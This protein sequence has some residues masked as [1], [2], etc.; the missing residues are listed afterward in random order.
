MKK[1]LSNYIEEHLSNIVIISCILFLGIFC[2]I[3]LFNF[4]GSEF[5]ENV[6]N[7][8]KE[9]MNLMQNDEFNGINIICKQ[10]IINIIVVLFLYFTAITFIPNFLIS[11]ITFFKGLCVGIYT[12]LIF[13]LFNGGMCI[14]AE[15][16]IV[17]IPL[18]IYMC[19]YIFVCNCAVLLHNQLM[20]GEFK[21]SHIILE[22]V[23]SISAISIILI[24]ILIEQLGCNVIIHLL[25]S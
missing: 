24:S 17:L 2:G 9:N 10:L 23:R 12:I 25:I 14:I 1:I 7:T 18:I 16:L 8:M 5:K 19:A 21:L 4:S 22:I 13:N 6:I 15:L 20:Q 3:C 11:L